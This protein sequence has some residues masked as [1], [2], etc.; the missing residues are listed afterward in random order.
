MK[1]EM[2]PSDPKQIAINLTHKPGSRLLKWDSTPGLN[3]ILFQFPY[4]DD[5]MGGLENVCALLEDYGLSEG[6]YKPISDN[7]GIWVR[8]V[9]YEEYQKEK[10]C[11]INGE[12]C[13]YL[14][15][16]C[17]VDKATGDVQIFTPTEQAMMKPYCSISY[18]MSIRIGRHKTISGFG[19]FKKEVDSG[20]F[21][22]NFPD[23]ALEG[24]MDGSIVYQL[25][26]IE[27]PITGE[28][29]KQ[30]TIYIESETT[31]V[32]VS[33]NKGLTLK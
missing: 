10:G 33:N 25:G 16:G 9:P 18:E 30:K 31:P 11:E 27:V 2:I 21:E 28:M 8:Y 6:E 29:L 14:V 7:K 5:V 12:A 19:P 17:I 26:G 3:A 4:G 15:V 23:Q 32:F 22:V 1:V 20:F 24:Y 13:T